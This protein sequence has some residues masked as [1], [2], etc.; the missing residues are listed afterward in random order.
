MLCL[1]IDGTLLNSE[2]HIS[3]KTKIAINKVSHGKNIPV[4]LVSARMPKGIFFL[5]KELGI[6]SPIICYSGA[7]IIDQDKNMILNHYIEVSYIKKLYS[8]VKKHKICISL[9]KD[10]EWYSEEKDKWVEQEGVITNIT[11]KIQD[12]RELFSCWE[13]QGCN[14]I[15]CMG[16][17][18]EILSLKK[19]LLAIFHDDLNIYL[20]K[21]TYLE[22]MPKKSTKTAAIQVLLERYYIDRSELIAIG[23]NY[24]DIDMIQYAGLGIAMGN[25]P[26]EVKHYAN[27]ITLSNDED[28]VASAINTYILR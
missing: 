24:N 5:A 20:S 13:N 22:I 8:I 25:A 10:D 18:E 9:Y 14:K 27:S 2:H 15:L 3:N 12:Y 6:S 17:E 21:S 26:D 23:D 1:D 7:L 11:A 16:D 28:G 4:I 19:E